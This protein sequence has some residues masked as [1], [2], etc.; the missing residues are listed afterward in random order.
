[1]NYKCYGWNQFH[2]FVCIV[3]VV[4]VWFAVA[5]AAGRK[6]A[7]RLFNGEADAKLDYSNIPTVVFSHPPVGTIGLTEGSFYLTTLHLLT[8][9]SLLWLGIMW[10]SLRSVLINPVSLTFTVASHTTASA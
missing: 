3:V 10:S 7:H 2:Y 1:M 4:V 5:I 9:S 6:L 8:R